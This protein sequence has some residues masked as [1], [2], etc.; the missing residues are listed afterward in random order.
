MVTVAEAKPAL[1]PAA[2]AAAGHAS[3]GA[4]PSLV[5]RVVV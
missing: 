3:V 4:V 1:T 5:A 2:A